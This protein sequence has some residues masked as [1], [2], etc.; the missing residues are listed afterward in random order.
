MRHL[1]ALALLC[2]ISAAAQTQNQPATSDTTDQATVPTQ[3]VAR[4]RNLVPPRDFV[5]FRGQYNMDNGQTLSI[6][7]RNR[8]YFAQFDTQP[9]MEIVA[10]TTDKF[11]STN[12]KTQLAFQQYPNGSVSGLTATIDANTVVAWADR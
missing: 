12:G 2:A 5:E 7:S 8:R 1:I 6:S 10:V 3:R 9:E 4:A 11:V